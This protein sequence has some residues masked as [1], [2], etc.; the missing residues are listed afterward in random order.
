[1]ITGRRFIQTLGLL[2]LVNADSGVYNYN[3]GGEDWGHSNL[4]CEHGEEQ[5]P[6]D[7]T[8]GSPSH[9]IK[10]ELS[11]TYKE[12]FD[13]TITKDTGSTVK[14]NISGGGLKLTFNSGSKSDFVPLNLHVHAPSEHTI[15]GVN[16]DLEMHFVHTYPDGS[17]GAVIGVFFDRKMGGTDDNFFIEELTPV[18][19]TA[20]TEN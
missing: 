18:F 15:D 1:M 8:G 2:T 6:I 19:N 7:L 16:A 14:V 4:L 5:S 17:L 10:V 9:S 11:D 20:P 3:L 13:A 12:F